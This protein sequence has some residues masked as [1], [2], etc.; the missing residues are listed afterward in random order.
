MGVFAKAGEV[1]TCENGHPICTVAR[2]IHTKDTM[3]A[4]QFKDWKIDIDTRPGAAIPF[5]PTCGA[6]FIAHPKGT[7]PERGKVFI[8][9]KWR[10]E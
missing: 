3:T 7:F 9:G 1:V 6:P 8:D 2:D 10:P 4:G 5:C